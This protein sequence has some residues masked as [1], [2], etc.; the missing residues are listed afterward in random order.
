[1]CLLKERRNCTYQGQEFLGEPHRSSGPR[2]SG[3]QGLLRLIRVS[4]VLADNH[5]EI[6]GIGSTSGD[7]R[8]S[9]TGT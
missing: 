6:P 1:M 8:V 4:R 2:V 7:Q 3:Y 9:G 5:G